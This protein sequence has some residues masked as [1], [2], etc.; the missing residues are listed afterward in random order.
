MAPHTTIFQSL[1]H[2]NPTV[3][4]R[5]RGTEGKNSSLSNT[6]NQ[7]YA[8]PVKVVEWA[9]MKDLR[10][11]REVFGG[12]L[13]EE[14]HREGRELKLSHIRPSDRSVVNEKRASNLFNKWNKE[15][16]MYALDPILETYRPLI[17]DQGENL[18]GITLSPPGPHPRKTSLNRL[19]PDSGSIASYPD[20]PGEEGQ[21]KFLKEYKVAA[22]WKSKWI[23][24]RRVINES[25]TWRGVKNTTSWPIMQVLKIPSS[26]EKV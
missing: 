23:K 1:T 22:K 2:P 9:E 6:T 13:F 4:Q 14:A 18:A 19:E 20:S 17:W 25:G 8:N 7:D 12:K 26:C 3:N 24:E 21:E 16:V 10:V 5:G 11:F 15:V